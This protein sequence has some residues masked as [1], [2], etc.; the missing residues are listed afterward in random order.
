[1]SLIGSLLCF[2]IMFLINWWA[3]LVTFVIVGG[4]Y[5]YVHTTKPGKFTIMTC[6]VGGLYTPLNQVSLQ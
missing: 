4:L 6:M 5:M 2:A 1:M 3:A